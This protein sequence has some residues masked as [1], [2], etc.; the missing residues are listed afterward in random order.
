MSITWRKSRQVIWHCTTRPWV[1]YIYIIYIVSW[2]STQYNA[3][4]PRKPNSKVPLQ[5]TYLW[6]YGILSSN[7]QEWNKEHMFFGWVEREDVTS[8]KM[9]DGTSPLPHCMKQV[10]CTTYSPCNNGSLQFKNY[11]HGISLECSED[12]LEGVFCDVVVDLMG[13][14]TNMNDVGIRVLV[15]LSPEWRGATQSANRTV[16]CEMMNPW[17]HFQYYTD[18]CAEWKVRSFGGFAAQMVITFTFASS[19]HFKSF[20]SLVN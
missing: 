17:E 12:E 2:R 8:S 20:H 3:K 7:D 14:V 18:L 9:A 13:I 6:Y 1:I 16:G 19:C 11:L 5:Q 4:Y 15:S 10:S